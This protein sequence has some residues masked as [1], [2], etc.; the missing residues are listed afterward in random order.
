MI[1]QPEADNVGLDELIPQFNADRRAAA[2]REYEINK[3]IQV[4]MAMQQKFYELYVQPYEEEVQELQVENEANQLALMLNAKRIGLL[5][6]AQGVEP[7]KFKSLLSV[8]FKKKPVEYKYDAE[9][10]AILAKENDCADL[11][12]VIVTEKLDVT[13][14]KQG[15]RSGLYKWANATPIEDVSVTLEPTGDILIMEGIV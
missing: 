15:L 9:A 11:V 8:S 12:K 6:N 5:A 3:R 14:F 10:V 7:S 2:I 1:D 4:A 13:T